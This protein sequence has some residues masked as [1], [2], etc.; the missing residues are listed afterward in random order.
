MLEQMVRDGRI[1]RWKQDDNNMFVVYRGCTRTTLPF[2]V[3]QDTLDRL[4]PE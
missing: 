1:L 4:F 3:K 2:D